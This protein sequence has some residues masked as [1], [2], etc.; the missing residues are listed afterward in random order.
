MVPTAAL[1]VVAW[2]MST[3]LRKFGATESFV[4]A[5]AIVV[6]FLLLLYLRRFH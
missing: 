3:R 6:T 1:F 4:P 2:L 5:I